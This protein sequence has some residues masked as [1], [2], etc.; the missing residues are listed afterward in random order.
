MRARGVIAEQTQQNTNLQ[1]RKCAKD[2]F[3]HRCWQEDRVKRPGTM[4]A[5]Y[6]LFTSAF[7]FD[8]ALKLSIET[9]NPVRNT[10]N[11]LAEM[12]TFRINGEIQ[13]QIARVVGRAE[14]TV[15][16]HNYLESFPHDAPSQV[17][18]DRD[19]H[20]HRHT[21]NIHSTRNTL[22]NP[23]VESIQERVV[24]DM[25]QV[26]R[27]RSHTHVL[28]N[29]TERRTPAIISRTIEGRFITRLGH[30]TI[31]KRDGRP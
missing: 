27:R 13:L 18:L 8:L 19:I 20:T 1:F 14:C 24:L 9:L 11:R 3:R 6:R 2:P 21:Y 4:S 28:D 29:N 5:A 25:Q 30:A 16:K 22:N 17:A 26:A 12:G 15:T 31:T 7:H 10:A 23:V